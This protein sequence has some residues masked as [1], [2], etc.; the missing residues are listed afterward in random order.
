MPR[1]TDTQERERERVE[2]TLASLGATRIEIQMARVR[3]EQAIVRFPI[4]RSLLEPVLGYLDAWEGQVERAG[5]IVR[6]IWDGGNDRRW[7]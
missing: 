3:V 2:N 1:M 6:E 5:R 7:E 4:T